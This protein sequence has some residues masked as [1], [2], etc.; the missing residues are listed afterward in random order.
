MTDWNRILAS[1]GPAVWKTLWR[2]LG[3]HSDVEECFQ[4]TF[5]AAL[6]VARREPVD[7]W[8][9][10]LCRLATARALDCLR[11]RYRSAERREPVAVKEHDSA[12]DQDAARVAE[13]AASDAGPVAQAMAAELC[14]RLRQAVARL[15]EKQAEILT[16]HTLDG[17]SRRDIAKRLDMT[18]NAVGVALHRARQQL[19]ERL[20]E[21]T[22]SES[23][24]WRSSSA[25]GAS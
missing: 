24:P 3:N 6:R 14:E 5:V 15:P 1:E 11:K 7:S 18:D 4:E 22:E 16:L 21:F 10:L 17:W 8:P 13:L 23:T 9:A 19:Q 2:L 25:G 20:R 12:A